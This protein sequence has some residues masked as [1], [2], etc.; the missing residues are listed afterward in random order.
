MTKAYWTLAPRIG[1]GT[2]EDAYRPDINSGGEF[3]KWTSPGNLVVAKPSG[4]AGAHRHLLAGTVAMPHPTDGHWH[5]VIQRTD[6]SIY[7]EMVDASG[8]VT[9]HNHTGD[10]IP[11]FYLVFVYTTDQGAVNIESNNSNVRQIAPT[12]I[13]T[14]PETGDLAGDV[15]DV[16]YTGGELTWLTNT[17]QNAMGLELPAVVDRPSRFVEWILPISLTRVVKAERAYRFAQ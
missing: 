9:D 10:L 14:D 11:D 8:A 3:S 1:T 16:L 6:G 2:S 17:L 7:Q 12:E 15:S 4:G 5:R 13:V